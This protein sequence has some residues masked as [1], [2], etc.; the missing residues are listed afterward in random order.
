MEQKIYLTNTDIE[1]A[2][3][4]Y[5]NKLESAVST[6]EKEIVDIREGLGRVT[7]RPVFARVSAP[8]HNAAAM[9]GIMAIAERT[10]SASEANPVDLR[11]VE[12]FE[13]INTGYQIRDPYDCV[14]MAEDIQQLESGEV[15]ISASASPWQHIRP[16]G[17]DIVAGEMV[18][19]ENHRIRPIDIGAVL[20]S[21]IVQVEVYE[22]IRIGIMPTGNEIIEDYH[23]LKAGNYFD[24][25][26]WTFCAIVDEWGG[27]H[28]RIPPVADNRD[29]LKQ[30]IMALLE[31]NHMVIVNA[32]SSAGTKDYTAHLI[33][34][35]GELVFHGLAIRPGKPTVLGI[36]EG[37]PVIG[38]PGYPGSAFLSFE[39]IVGPVFR[40]L[41]RTGISKNPGIDAV[42]SRR[43]VSS[44]K[45]R[46][47]I[48]VKVGK[49]EGKLIATPLNRGAGVTM[50]LV[51]ADGLMIIPKNSEGY[52]A[53]EKVKVELTRDIG[54]IEN[55][56]VSIGSHDLI[57][58]YIASMLEKVHLS[59]A[60]VGSL[61]GIMALARGEAHIAP[62]H[63]LDEETGEYNTSY[64]KKYLG[65]KNI[66]LVKGVKRQQGF[67]V[68]KGNPKNIHTV[69]DLAR[70]QVRFVNR[71]KGSGTRILTDYLLKKA[72]IDSNRIR[73]YDRDMTTHMAIAAA[74]SS[75]TADVGVGVFSAAK[76]M[77]LDFIPIGY[78]EYDFAIPEQ[79]IETLMIREFIKVLKSDQFKEVL[80][81]LGG[82]E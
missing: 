54:T 19:P 47:Y 15:R 76:S 20:N 68:A 4:H 51:K 81:E 29:S 45:Y 66:S 37:K 82:Y 17:E 8:N 50:S 53:G 24:T 63:L 79:Y 67:M 34:E 44:L 35:M 32:G 64:I 71:Q 28:D 46:E 25:N 70:E 80:K 14:I 30:A 36:I 77:D 7:A 65:N 16:I 33:E 57:M 23:H 72:H 55:T 12:D 73:G 43:V 48:R 56:I 2:V 42:L 10:F 5:L 60:H 61:G 39:E 75:G 58:D 31:R 26:S 41:Q 59:S 11:P 27:I 52:E 18:L 21:G 3:A 1:D 9:D 69:E 6:V 22:R 40:K 74:V 62:I 13:F 38:V 49:V 78:E